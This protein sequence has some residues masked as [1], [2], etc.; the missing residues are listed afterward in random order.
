[1][2]GQRAYRAFWCEVGVGTRIYSD[3]KC[4]ESF[5]VSRRESQTRTRGRVTTTISSVD[6]ATQHGS[7]TRF[8]TQS[9]GTPIDAG[10]FRGTGVN[11]TNL[12][13]ACNN[14]MGRGGV[15]FFRAQKKGE[16]LTPPSKIAQSGTY[17][18][19]ASY[20]LIHSFSL[21]RMNFPLPGQAVFPLSMRCRSCCEIRK[22]CAASVVVLKV[23]SDL[24]G[25]VTITL[26][27]L[28]LFAPCFA[29][30][31]LRLVSSLMTL[32]LIIFDMDSRNSGSCHLATMSGLACGP[33]AFWEM[34]AMTHRLDFAASS[35]RACSALRRMVRS[36]F[37]QSTGV[38]YW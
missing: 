2:I 19:L 10:D 30:D 1:M 28:A 34:F 4:W 15:S 31:I 3:H 26:R 37:G 17:T 36:S 20:S 11:I 33:N 25:F 21:L 8:R 5:A 32:D 18:N 23:V 13:T 27:A 14:R 9:R 12:V 24:S 29:S 35:S 6:P 7:T 16:R 22:N 38:M